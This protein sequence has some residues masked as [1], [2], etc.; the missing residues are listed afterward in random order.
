[1]KTLKPAAFKKSSAA[2]AVAAVLTLAL[3]ACGGPAEEP[4]E[5]PGNA[6]T[7][8]AAAATPGGAAA[9]ETPS[10]AAATPAAEA[11][12]T[13]SAAASASPS[14]AATAVAAAAPAGPPETFKQCAACHKVAPGKHGIGPSLAGVFGEKAGHLGAAFKYSDQMLA[15]GLTWDQGTLDRYLADPRG[16]VP[17]TKMAFAGVK[18]AGKRAELIAYL[19]TL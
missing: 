15:S 6:A 7:D 17:G 8:A 5:V 1:M 16:T 11:S 9:T 14:P 2:L 13:P 19:K 4:M 12:A 18:D 10:E 3:A